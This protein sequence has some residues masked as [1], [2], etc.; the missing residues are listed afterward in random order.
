[1]TETEL[2]KKIV[3]LYELFFVRT[4]HY[5]NYEFNPSERDNKLIKS[6]IKKFTKHIPLETISES[7]IFDYFAYQFMSRETQ[8]TSFGT[9]VIMLNWVIGEKS[10]KTWIDR[11]EGWDYHLREFLKRIGVEKNLI[12]TKERRSLLE[13]EE[14]L[15]KESFNTFQ[16]FHQCLTMTR[17]FSE[18]SELCIQ[19]NFSIDCKK[20]RDDL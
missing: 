13:Y 4:S 10:I 7:L 15:K 12:V 20:I 9:G 8:K 2:E 16:G 11:F 6:F 1:M 3:E 5:S 17:L 14:D 18:S 19:C